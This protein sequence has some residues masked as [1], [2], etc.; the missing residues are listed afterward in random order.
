MGDI[1]LKPNYKEAKKRTSNDIKVLKANSSNI[2]KYKNE[3]KQIKGEYIKLNEEKQK[4]SKKL[5][6]NKK[7]DEELKKD[8]I[9]SESKYNRLKDNN[10]NCSICLEN[11]I[12]QKS[13]ISLTPCNHIF[14]F[15]CFKE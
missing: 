13:L 7:F 8:K 4:L 1:M 2:D 14:H 12:D 11:Y 5:E 15:N 6:E 9:I 3:L 10:T